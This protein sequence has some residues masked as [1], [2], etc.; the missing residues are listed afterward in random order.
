MGYNMKNG[1]SELECDIDLVGSEQGPMPG[2]CG[3]HDEISCSLNIGNS[4]E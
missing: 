3:P 1:I 4:R 2:F